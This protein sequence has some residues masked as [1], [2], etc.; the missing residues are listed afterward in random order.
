MCLPTYWVSFLNLKNFACEECRIR[1]AIY[2]VPHLV[3]LFFT[4]CIVTLNNNA[5]R[6]HFDKYS[7]TQWPVVCASAEL[8][9]SNFPSQHR[10]LQNMLSQQP[11]SIHVPLFHPGCW[12]VYFRPWTP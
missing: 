7:E 12:F 1:G 6:G 4:V 2:V 10:S 9:A 8:R 11:R 3:L 5:T